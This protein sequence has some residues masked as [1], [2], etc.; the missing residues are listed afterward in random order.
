MALMQCP[1]CSKEISDNA[2]SCPSCGYT[3]TKNELTKIR[4]SDLSEVKKNSALGTL[5]IIV[6]VIVILVGIPLITVIIGIFAIVG[7]FLF[8]ALGM[9][10]LSGTQT[11]N[12]PYCNHSITVGAKA[13][14]YKCP[15]CKK[16]STKKSYRLETI[17]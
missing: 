7:G 2:E 5:Y 11:G 17:D 9:N 3:L 6:G 4:K 1:E 12:C 10:N 16:I 13:A 8:I 15:H 14:T